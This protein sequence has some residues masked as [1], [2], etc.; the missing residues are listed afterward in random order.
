MELDLEQMTDDELYDLVGRAEAIL[1]KRQTETVFEDELNEVLSRGVA[2]GLIEDRGHREP[3]EPWS[4][5]PKDL[6]LKGAEFTHRGRV[7]RSKIPN[8]VTEPGDPDDPQAWRWWEDITDEITDPEEGDAPG[9]EDEDTGEE[10][11]PGL[12]PWEPE[13]HNYTVGD[14][15]DHEGT[16]YRVLQDHTSQPHWTPDA[17][18]AL[19]EKG[20]YA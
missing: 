6:I 12:P 9:E 20:T 7:W 4:G 3:W 15:F 5:D 13:G 16:P 2:A 8:N 18:P 19:Y 14:Q 17:V 11:M 10:E 1:G